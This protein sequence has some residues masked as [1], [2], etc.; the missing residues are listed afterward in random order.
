[1]AFPSV[2]NEYRLY[3]RNIQVPGT[4]RITPRIHS[5]AGEKCQLRIAA[6]ELS[7]RYRRKP[8]PINRTG[9]SVTLVD[10][11]VPHLGGI[12]LGGRRGEGGEG[13]V[14]GTGV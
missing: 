10:K 9:V 11:L 1:M 6:V 4:N 14:C 7:S 3:Q 5:L 13:C 12:R 2:Y 8:Q